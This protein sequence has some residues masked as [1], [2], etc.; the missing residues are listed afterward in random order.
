LWLSVDPGCKRPP[1]LQA[2][3]HA[4]QLKMPIGTEFITGTRFV[5]LRAS[6]HLSFAASGARPGLQV[7]DVAR[8]NLVPLSFRSNSYIAYRD[9]DSRSCT[10]LAEQNWRVGGSYSFKATTR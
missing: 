7:V 6:S 9:D 1:S 5:E 10:A 2:V 8:L 3:G 4:R